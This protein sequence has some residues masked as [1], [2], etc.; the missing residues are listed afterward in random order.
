MKLK[1]F[2]KFVLPGILKRGEEYYV[3]GHVV[4]IEEVDKGCY[5]AEVE[6][7]EN[8]EVEVR[9]GSRGDIQ[10]M[11]CDCPYDQE[12][13]C[14]HQVAVL[15]EIRSMLDVLKAKTDSAPKGKAS[16]PKKKLADQLKALSKE[17]AISVESRS[18]KR[19]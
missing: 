2:E 9:I 7:S 12:A 11:A 15:L 16:Q 10:S 5:Q 4:D 3:E 18:F 8:Y 19:T 14:K 1:D 17:P 13:F 6:G